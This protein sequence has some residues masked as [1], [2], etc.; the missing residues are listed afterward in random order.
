MTHS[1]PGI[2]RP[3]FSY[4]DDYLDGHASPW[5]AAFPDRAVTGY[6]E[7]FRKRCSSASS[8]GLVDGDTARRI[9]LEILREYESYEKMGMWIPDEILE[10]HR[11]IARGL[12][13]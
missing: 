9:W 5:K 13:W 4:I 12:G 6:S 3:M 10:E 8:G 7:A 2:N 1:L 11:E